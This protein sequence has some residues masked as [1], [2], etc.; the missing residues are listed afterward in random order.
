MR[1]S[2][3][4]IFGSDFWMPFAMLI[5]ACALWGISYPVIKALD[6]E[7]SARLPQASQ[8]YL[9]SWTQMAR[10][11]LAAVLMLPLVFRSLP[12]RQELRQAT[13]L[14]L[15]GGAGMALLTWGLAYTEASTTA[16]LIQAYCV[17]LPLIDCLRTRRPPPPSI[18]VATALV[19]AGCTILS[20]IDSASLAIGKGEAAGLLA[21]L[22]FTFQIIALEDPKYSGN[23]GMPVTFAMCAVI[24]L[25]FLPVTLMLHPVPDALIA[26]AATLPAEALWMILSL[27]STACAFGLMISWQ[28][29]IHFTEAGLIY[30]MEPVFTAGFVLFLP[31]FLSR[32]VGHEYP[33]ESLTTRLVAGGSLIV[34]A[35]LLI[36]WRKRFRRQNLAS[37]A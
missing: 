3:S 26:P 14:A 34:A 8:A 18:F 25:I 29:R 19:I 30:T 37:A 23:R 4:R 11:G 24:A 1:A 21:A 9:A 5:L 15:S 10:F 6:L 2:L 17:F 7:Q 13:S 16:F 32:M 33:N 12:T 28:P 36:Q 31:A 27:L 22:F 35:N 20:G